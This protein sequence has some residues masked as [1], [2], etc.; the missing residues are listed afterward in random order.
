MLVSRPS[1]CRIIPV[2]QVLKHWGNL[3]KLDPNTASHVQGP[4]KSNPKSLAPY[5]TSNE[6][7]L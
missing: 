7:L 4:M 2:S 5:F 1:V 6:T 3:G